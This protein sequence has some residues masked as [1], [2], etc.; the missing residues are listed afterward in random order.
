MKGE[1]DDA[2]AE[3]TLDGKRDA[4]E[5]LVNNEKLYRQVVGIGYCP[6]EIN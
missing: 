5:L 6:A 3:D 4:P 1:E 2:G